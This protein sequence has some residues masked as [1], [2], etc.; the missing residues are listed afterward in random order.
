MNFLQKLFKTNP[1]AESKSGNAEFVKATQ[2]K[3]NMVWKFLDETITYYHAAACPCAFP[4]FRQIVAIDCVDYRKSFYASETEGLI[5]CAYKHFTVSPFAGGAEVNND[6]WTCNTC[7]STYHFGWSDFSIHVNRTFLKV[8]DL[9][10]KDLGAAP[11]LPIPLHVG[12]FGHTF[13]DQTQIVPVDF[14]TF[15][16]YIREL[17]QQ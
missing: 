6:L 13:P 4:R 8:I 17:K 16:N 10:V 9:K 12:L 7:G 11:S 5:S 2:D 3:T 15:S 14:E 1:S